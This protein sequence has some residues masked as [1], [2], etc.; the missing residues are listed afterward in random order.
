MSG[1][2]YLVLIVRLYYGNPNLTMVIVTLFAIVVIIPYCGISN[3][4]MIKPL[5]LLFLF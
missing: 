1:V 2:S 4:V 5:L 3:L